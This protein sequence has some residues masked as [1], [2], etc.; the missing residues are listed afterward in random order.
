MIDTTYHAT[1]TIRSDPKMGLAYI[2]DGRPLEGRTYKDPVGVVMAHDEIDGDPAGS[3]SLGYDTLAQAIRATA[4][5]SGVAKAADITKF[6]ADQRASGGR[7][8]SSIMV[9]GVTKHGKLAYISTVPACPPGALHPVVDYA[10]R[11]L[12]DCIQVDYTLSKGVELINDERRTVLDNDGDGK[13]NPGP[14]SLLTYNAR[15]RSSGTTFVANIVPFD[16][17]DKALTDLGGQ[18]DEAALRKR[19]SELTMQPGQEDFE[20][21]AFVPLSDP[22]QAVDRQV[23]KTFKK[24]QDGAIFVEYR[25]G[26]QESI[27]GGWNGDDPQG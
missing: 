22:L 27:R 11:L 4:G 7:P 19:F 10:F 8:G 6:L 14:D 17:L 18:A 3:V 21:S 26:P 5:P 13:V 24:T 25:L 12:S 16:R 15:S 20:V 23:G 2:D 9:D 1:A